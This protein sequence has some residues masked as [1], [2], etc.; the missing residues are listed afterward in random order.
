MDDVDEDLSRNLSDLASSLS[1]LDSLSASTQLA[2][3]ELEA[4]E[5]IDL[6][7]SDNPKDMTKPILQNFFYHLPSNGKHVFCRYIA[8][9]HQQEDL[10]ALADHLNKAILSPSR[11][12]SPTICKKYFLHTSY[13]NSLA[14]ILPW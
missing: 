12:P 13:S 11:F 10:H 5:K 3:D 1:S 8:S 2:F 7:I 9:K 6:Y 4:K 14:N